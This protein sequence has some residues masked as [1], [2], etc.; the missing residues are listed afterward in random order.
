M[1]RTFRELVDRGHAAVGL[2]DQNATVIAPC[3]QFLADALGVPRHERLEI[4]LH[5]GRARALE[6]VVFTEDVAG[7]GDRPVGVDLLQ[8][9][10]GALLVSRVGVGVQERHGDCFDIHL[11]E[12]ARQLVQPVL[13]ERHLDDAFVVQPL[14]HFPAQVALDERALDAG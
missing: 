4:R 9:L 8:D 5:N 1:S 10:P 12:P 13:V 6:L 7:D 3:A 11:T 2:H 14:R